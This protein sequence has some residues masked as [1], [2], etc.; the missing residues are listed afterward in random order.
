[1]GKSWK[2]Y[3]LKMGVRE[4]SDLTGFRAK[5]SISRNIEY[6]RDKA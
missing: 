2:L 4:S 1:M 3:Q 6:R 5:L